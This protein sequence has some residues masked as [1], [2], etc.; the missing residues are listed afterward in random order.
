MVKDT[1]HLIINLGGAYTQISDNKKCFV[2][3]NRAFYFIQ[4]KG[5]LE[6]K[7]LCFT[8]YEDVETDKICKICNQ[9]LLSVSSN[10][11]LKGENYHY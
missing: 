2:C 6:D 8:C 11:N 1:L 9:N 5:G 3:K 4:D 7:Y 10:F